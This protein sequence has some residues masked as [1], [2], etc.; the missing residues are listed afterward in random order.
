MH[1]KITAEAW[2]KRVSRTNRLNLKIEQRLILTIYLS[3]FERALNVLSSSSS[4]TTFQMLHSFDVFL[5]PRIER[6]SCLYSEYVNA[7]KVSCLR[8]RFDYL[9]FEMIL[10]VFGKEF[11]VPM[12]VVAIRAKAELEIKVTQ[13]LLVLLLALYFRYL[14]NCMVFW[15]DWVKWCRLL[16]VV[17]L[18]NPLL[19]LSKND[20]V[21]LALASN[22]RFLNLRLI[23]P[24]FSYYGCN[25]PSLGGLW[26]WS[27]SPYRSQTMSQIS[28]Y[29]SCFFVHSCLNRCRWSQFWNLSNRVRAFHN[30][31]WWLA[32]CL[33]R[34]LPFLVKDSR[35][36][37]NAYL[38]WI[39]R[40]EI[41]ILT[42]DP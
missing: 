23:K 3:Y 40:Y 26:D 16:L 20:T 39:V 12:W 8:F 5:A 37:Y 25:T 6:I 9:C 34:W 13:T 30:Q 42:L 32:P 27:L 24:S 7:W 33:E 14:F 28:S 2:G 18:L 21:D 36:H 19:I 38:L 1:F 10:F 4:T 11:L 35:L 22:G 17:V 29:W 31:C 15:D 41:V